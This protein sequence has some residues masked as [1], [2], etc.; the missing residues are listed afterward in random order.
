MFGPVCCWNSLLNSSVQSIVFSSKFWFGLFYVL[1]Y[2]VELFILFLLSFLDFIKLFICVSCSSLSIFKIII[3]NSLLGILRSP[4]LW[5]QLLQIYHA[6]LVVSP[7]PDC[8]VIPIALH[9]CLHIWRS[10]HLLP[11]SWTDFSKK[12]PSL[13]GR[14]YWNML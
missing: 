5:V 8:F 10:C 6:P 2:L 4:F 1:Y 3:L 9:R 14:A 7:F 11:T 13:E 12:K